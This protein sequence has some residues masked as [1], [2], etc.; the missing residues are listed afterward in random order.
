MS[1]VLDHEVRSPYSTTLTMTVCLVGCGSAERGIQG[2]F[3]PAMLARA[4]AEL[5]AVAA[6]GQI[7]TAKVE[8]S[9]AFSILLTTDRTYSLAFRDPTKTAMPFFAQWVFDGDESTVQVVA[10]EGI[11]VGE[12]HPVVSDDV[13]KD[14]CR[15]LSES[16]SRVELR[17]SFIVSSERDL[18]EGNEPDLV[19][20]IDD[21]LVDTDADLRPDLLDD[22]SDGDG[23]CDLD[24]DGRRDDPGELEETSELPYD[25][26]PQLGDDFSIRD[27][28]LERGPPPS[29]VLSIE[30]ES[31]SWRLEE[32][33]DERPFE[34]MEDDCNHNGN[35]GP[36][37]DRIFVSW[38]NADGTADIDHLD[39]R[40]CD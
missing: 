1:L 9:G 29:Q 32:L 2:R 6:G 15:G 37:R 34:V 40:Y 19:S 24:D 38:L 27:A 14:H 35:R 5:V 11:D 4:Q 30:M 20:H 28:F 39:L 31:G 36:G 22:D 25:V 18:V 33:R 12:L 8:P 17:T 21:A 7:S 26:R 10:G 3:E 13:E 16:S 23:L